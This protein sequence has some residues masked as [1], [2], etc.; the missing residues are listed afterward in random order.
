MTFYILFSV[1]AI[2]VA[3]VGCVVIW[4]YD[5]VRADRSAADVREASRSG[6]APGARQAVA[7]RRTD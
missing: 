3:I 5:A 4:G 1:M 7:A 6:V 2:S